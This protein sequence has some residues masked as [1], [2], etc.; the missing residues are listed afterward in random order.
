MHP[1]DA[2][3]LLDLLGCATRRRMLELLSERP[4]FV[5]EIAELLDVGRKAV[6][7]HLSS[8]EDAG[9]VVSTERP[10]KKGRPR[11]YYEIEDAGFFKFTISPMNVEFREVKALR[12]L[13]KMEKIHNRLDELEA[14]P[15]GHRQVELEK[16]R[17]RLKKRLR[18][19][20]TEWV[21]TSR[22]LARARRIEF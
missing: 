16:I 22:L 11:K 2:E 9:L 8:L 6:I 5:S 4:R 15:P 17:A 20:E 13:P 18:E 12:E 1:A 7:D 14:M 21:E 3:A 10:I 19:L